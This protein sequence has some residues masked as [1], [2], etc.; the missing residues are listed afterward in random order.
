MSTLPEYFL[1]NVKPDSDSLLSGMRGMNDSILQSE[2]DDLTD[3]TDFKFL[4]Y[5]N[6]MDNSILALAA[7]SS[8]I[9]LEDDLLTTPPRSFDMETS[10]LS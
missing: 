4:T 10:I 3:G 6:T 7:E 8:G 2:E 5:N 9:N 1:E